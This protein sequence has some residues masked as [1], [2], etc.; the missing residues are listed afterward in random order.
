M[1]ILVVSSS[2][3]PK[4]RSR[5]LARRA[6]A[7]LQQCGTPAAYLDLQETPLPF[8]D[9]GAAYG[10]PNV[11]KATELV[12]AAQGIVLA[13][14]IYTYDVGAAAKNLVEL[15]GKQWEGKVVSFLCAA[16]GA[17]SY[18]SVM[19][20]ANS[21]MLDFRC[22]IVPRFVYATADSFADGELRD[23]KVEER[24]VQLAD[25]TVRLVAALA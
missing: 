1:S 25:E 16:G 13:A 22:L 4:S 3:D 20:L 14:P 15:T 5:V 6:L 19:G 24:V 7:R 8:C 11:R 18:M 23:A 12:R 9:A 21:L 2:L 10:D 17:S